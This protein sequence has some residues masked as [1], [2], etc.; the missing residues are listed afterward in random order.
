MKIF[1]IFLFLTA[2]LASAGELPSEIPTELFGLRLGETYDIGNPSAGLLGSMPV[3]RFT[4]SEKFLGE[5]F[6]YYFEPR[7]TYKAF[8]FIVDKKRRGEKFFGS[9]FRAYLLPVI[10]NTI[11][12]TEE[13]EK[14]DF[15]WR[16]I[17]IEWSVKAETEMDT[18][19]WAMDLCRTFE[20]DFGKKPE[21]L[22]AISNDLAYYTCKFQSGDRE[23]KIEGMGGF[24]TIQLTYNNKVSIEMQNVVEK[25]R[26][27]L[28]AKDIN[29][30]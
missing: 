18:Y 30:Q 16:P 10:P 23:F 7:K 13:L 8:S 24:K 5:G 21:V 6:S 29:P 17:L 12:S 2:Q 9:P 28:Q 19:T 27:K 14:G 1:P 15:K 22:E 4:G 25:I 3:K 26:R 11:K 20:L